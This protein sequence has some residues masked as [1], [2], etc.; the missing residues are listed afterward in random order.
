MLRP[1]RR[2]QQNGAY[3]RANQEK[4]ESGAAPRSPPLIPK[5]RLVDSRGGFPNRGRADSSWRGRFA[6]CHQRSDCERTIRLR[7]FG[8][9]PGVRRTPT[10]AGGFCR[11]LRSWTAWTGARRRR[12]AGWIARHRV[13]WSIASTGGGWGPKRVLWA[14]KRA[15]FAQIGG[16]GPDREKD[17]VV[18]WRRLD[19]KRVI[20][21]RFG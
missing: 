3:A 8:R 19:L 5:A 20:A 6:P 7:R 16:A 17:G 21:E 12:S 9:S 2:R 13:T 11:W 18:R 15:R 4:R 1:P 14:E 10:R